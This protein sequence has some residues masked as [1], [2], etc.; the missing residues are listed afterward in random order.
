MKN[1]P[2]ILGKYAGPEYFCD[3]EEE[4]KRLVELVTNGNNVMLTSP[5][6]IGKTDLINHLFYQPEIRDEYITIK[7][8]IY[9]TQSFNDFIAIFGKAITES[10]KSRGK[11]I[12]DKF[13]EYLT[14]VRAELTFDQQGLPVWGLGVGRSVVPEV[15]LEEIFRYIE[16]APHPCLIAI[17]EFQQIASFSNGSQVE[18]LLR[19]YIQDCGNAQFIFSGSQRHLMTEMFTSPA[20]PFFQ[21]A[22]LMG[23]PLIKPE[24]YEDFCQELFARGGKHLCTGVATAVYNQ[25]DGITAYMHQVMNQ[26]Y[27]T[28][29]LSGNCASGDVEAAIDSIISTGSEAYQAL[30]NQIPE[31]QR[32]LLL[33]V[34][35]EGTV[36]SV[37]SGAFIRKHR[38]LS[39]SSVATSARI[40]QEKDILVREGDRY[41]IYDRFFALWLQR[42]V[43]N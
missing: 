28:T 32:D 25:F 36:Q 34:A 2:F 42:T 11:A 43:L 27:A 38:L 12:V 24:V 7:V 19:T 4:T 18:A 8:D 13:L 10:L 26:L 3:R 35:S 16:Q 17:D 14:S 30:Y 40:L 9:S 31:R 21:S 37:T 20:R 1:N 29:P 15:T 41:C 39:A 5:R 23:L 6:R 33:A 22:T